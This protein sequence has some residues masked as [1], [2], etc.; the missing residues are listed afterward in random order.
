VGTDDIEN[1][2]PN[3]KNFNQKNLGFLV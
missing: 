1:M 3:L 2:F